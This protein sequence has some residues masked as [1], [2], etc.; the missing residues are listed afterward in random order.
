MNY[1]ESIDYLKKLT[2]FGINFGLGRI[3]NL[4][5]RLGHP[6]EELD[7]VHVGGT[8]GKGSTCA[9]LASILDQSGLKVGLFTS[10]HI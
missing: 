3:Q 10:P 5:A 8:N 9:M 7:C 1:Q 4:L 6:E 2:T